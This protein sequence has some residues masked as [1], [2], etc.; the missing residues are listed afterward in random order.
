MTSSASLAVVVSFGLTLAFGRIV[1]ELARTYGIV[2]RPDDYRKLHK[3]A[4]P[5]GGGIAVLLSCCL[6]IALTGAM[7]GY[8]TQSV[9]WRFLYASLTAGTGITLL[10][11]VDDIWQLSG[12][13]KFIG[14]LVIVLLL[15]VN[16]PQASQVRFLHLEFELGLLALPFAAL[17]LLTSVNA[18][19]LLD[20]ADGFAS[21]IGIVT[22]AAMMVVAFHQGA[23]TECLFAAAVCGSLVAFMAFNFPPSSLFLGDAGSM[24]IGLVIGMLAL[25]MPFSANGVVR[26]EYAIGL[27]ALPFADTG[28]AI[29]RRW[30]T[31][32]NFAIADRGHLHHCLTRRG[33]GPR[34]LVLTAIG[35]SL[36]PTAGVVVAIGWNHLGFVWLGIAALLVT[37]LGLKLFGLNEVG[38][39]SSRCMSFVRRLVSPFRSTTTPRPVEIGLS[40]SVGGQRLWRSLIDFATAEQLSQVSVHFHGMW[41]EDG[42]DIFC[43]QRLSTNAGNWQAKLPIQ[44]AEK[45]FGTVEISGDVSDTGGLFSRLSVLLSDLTPCI[46]TIYADSVR[47]SEALQTG[48]ADRVLFVNRS[49]WPDSE[50]TGQLLTDLCEDL[51]QEFD[52]SVLAGQPNHVSRPHNYISTGVQFKDDVEIYRVQHSTFTKSSML[53]KALNLVSFAACAFWK[54]FWIPRHTVVVVETDPFLLAIL[55]ALVKKVRG[56]KL[57]IYVQDLYPDVAIAIGKVK[58]GWLTK[59]V[60]T[61]LQ[62][63][64][65]QAD[66][67]VVLGADM[68][69]RL[70]S[71][72][73]PSEKIRVIPNWCDTHTIYPVKTANAFRATHELND[74]FV[75]MHSGNMGLT[76][77]LGDLIEAATRLQHR[78]DIEFVLVGGGASQQSLER[79]VKDRALRNVRFLPYQ[80]REELATSLSAADL[81]VVS[82]HK[83]ICGCLVPSKTYGIMAS[84]TATLAIAPAESDIARLVANEKIGLT[85]SPGDVEKIVQ[86]IEASANGV[87]DLAMMGERAREIA[88]ER[89]DRRDSVARFEELLEEFIDRHERRAMRYE[90][91]ENSIPAPHRSPTRVPTR[92][93]GTPVS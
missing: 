73:V 58:E 72:G 44:T 33:F 16:F 64:Y 76:Q 47:R 90:Q 18:M 83:N 60:Q 88:E 12:K 40:R 36:L 37:L 25:R 86:A 20:G 34:R 81:Q 42:K 55:G 67:M 3:T 31:G 39:L 26:I 30:S 78:E 43:Q 61:L 19:N 80:P 62:K 4:T 93:K 68:K 24:L 22:A 75:V 14:Q 85:V 49:Y 79:L 77:E 2:D 10:G 21:G 5:Y 56:S 27:L 46:E 69:S 89:F 9:N 13:Q 7:A 53:G 15:L 66:A 6:S 11:F 57:I 17:W 74:K 1:R 32:R 29:V 54:V 82:M 41:M 91:S 71:H 65:E 50:A 51:A 84:G 59:L 87:F 45:T 70:I 8:D 28:A 48:E 35:L 92:S 52:V 23:L 38:L 63:S